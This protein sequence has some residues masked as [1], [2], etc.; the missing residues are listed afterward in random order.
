MHVGY[1]W[2][3]RSV[4]IDTYLIMYITGLPPWREDP[5]LFFF[6]KKNEKTL[7][8]TMREKFYMKRA[9]RDLDVTSI[10]DPTVRFATKL[11]SC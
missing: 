9:Q 4:Y 1:L 5:T 3:D 2:L 8:K 7:A 6:N 11:I 10:C